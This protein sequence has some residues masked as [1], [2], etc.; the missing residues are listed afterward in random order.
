MNPWQWRILHF[1][2]H[3]SRL[4]FRIHHRYTILRKKPQEKKVFCI[5]YAKTG[6]K[7]LAKALD[8]LGYRTVRM[9]KIEDLIEHDRNSFRHKI[10]SL[11]KENWHSYIEE[12][13]KHKYDAYV[14][15]PMGYDNLYK[16]LDAEFPDAHFILTIR[17]PNSLAASYE[18]FYTGS[19]F[20][21]TTEE[22][23]KQKMREYSRR[24]TEIL[25]YFKDRPNK[26]LVLNIIEGDS[27]EPLCAFLNTPIPTKKFPKK[28]VARY[29]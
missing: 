23:L 16:A 12:I 21:T 13:K 26:I 29:G 4:Y 24:N 25:D 11:R 7:S 5:G 10:E 8:I 14:D 9:F 15:F 27:W 22:E 1:C 3:H 2:M 20:Q 17:D 6:T 28:N 18:N 19:Y